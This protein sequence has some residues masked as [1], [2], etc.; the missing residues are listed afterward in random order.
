MFT[1]FARNE[2]MTLTA[3]EL[4]M[5]TPAL[6]IQIKQKPGA[7]GMP[8]YE[9]MGRWFYLTGADRV[10]PVRQTLDES[11]GAFYCVEG[12]RVSAVASVVCGVS[13]E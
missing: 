7:I 1:V 13:R 5:S 2:N 4:H 6:S 8:L 10:V 3:A 9:Q 12:E 11:S